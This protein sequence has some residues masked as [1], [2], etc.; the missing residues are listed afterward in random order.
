MEKRNKWT[1]IIL[2][3][4]LVAAL[5]LG[6]V[7]FVPQAVRAQ[8]DQPEDPTTLPMPRFKMPGI[9]GI[10]GPE[11]FGFGGDIDYDAYLAEALDITVEEL[12][13]ARETAR[14]KALEEAVE[15]GYITE[16]QVANM[17]ARQA[18]MQNLD[19]EALKAQL[20]A[21]KEEGADLRSEMKTAVQEALQAA[22]DQALA[23]GTIT[24]DQADMILAGG[25]DGKFGGR[26]G[27]FDRGDFHH[28]K[29]ESTPDSDSD[30]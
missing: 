11:G 16:E 3:G 2:I 10:G 27:F 7:V 25:L 4:A 12:Q 21:L 5:A 17:T 15:K 28:P 26:G 19:L 24:Q 9:R 30:V 6:A 20:D 8:D 14:T 1:R 22:V 29:F 13:A 23:E 18:V